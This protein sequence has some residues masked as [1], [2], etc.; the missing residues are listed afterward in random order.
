VRFPSKVNVP[1]TAQPV[2][3]GLFPEVA[4]S[5]TAITVDGGVRGERQGTTLSAAFLIVIVYL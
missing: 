2:S 4:W 3:G 1:R 5:V